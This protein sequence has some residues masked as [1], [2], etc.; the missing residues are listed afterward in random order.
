V[1][2]TEQEAST[3]VP[4]LPQDLPF[5]QEQKQWM[6]GFLAG[7]H[8]RLLVNGEAVTSSSAGDAVA[9]KTLD[10]IVGT[11]TGN[12]ETVAEDAAEYARSQGLAP[13]IHDMD[14]ISLAQL[15]KTERL[16]VVTSTYG[17]GEMPDNAQGLWDDINSDAAPRFENT[18][19]SVLALGDTNY[20]GFCV[21]GQQ[22]DQRLEQ[23]GAT[24]VAD[25]VDCDVDFEQP[26]ETWISNVMPII[27]LK[28]REGKAVTAVNTAATVV[29]KK[30]KFSRN[31]PLSATLLAKKLL[32]KEGSSKE[33]MH[34]EFSLG[35]SGETYEAGDALNIISLNQPS[36]IE[37]CLSIFDAKADEQVL[38]KDESHR[39]AELFEKHL[40]IRTPS[41]DLIAE[42][43]TRSQDA[44]LNRL[45]ENDDAEALSDFLWGK[46][47]VDLLKAY[48]GDLNLIDF[49]GLCRPL[50]PRAYS[51]SSSINAHE[52]EVHLTIASVRYEHNERRYNGLCSTYLADLVETNQTVD[53]YFSA[54][55]SFSV[56]ADNSAPM[57][58]VGPGTGIAPFRA[59]LEERQ[60]RQAEGDNWLFFGDRNRSSDYIYEE[61]I[62]AMKESG[63]LTR[64]DLAFSRDQAEK[65]YVQDLMQQAG[66][67]LFTWFE[68]GAYF[69]ICG[70]AYRMAKD[71]DKVLH[72][73]ISEHGK[74]DEAE[75]ENYVAQL[76]KDK[77]YVRDVY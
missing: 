48:R 25:R 23:L 40:E 76:K 33:I 73:I 71:V 54:N 17:E 64:L 51:I 30:P 60:A 39:V 15:A 18:F 11:Q 4:Y 14:E 63:L 57:I 13:M 2:N 53:C 66:A 6:G 55:K 65:I 47:C 45:L 29:K 44:E 41:K 77:R 19:Y 22:W 62:E 21:A 3:R 50:A 69:Y 52:N 49:I 61:E 10:I 1:K 58:M 67:E 46:D 68:K 7:L 32:N 37:A 5:N 28:G 27:A 43:A 74:L 56:P 26:A 75:T 31:N 12:A 9:Q 36:L 72:Q 16:L 42:L 24:R 34:Y 38:W 59:F 8:T 35:S 20:D 70:D